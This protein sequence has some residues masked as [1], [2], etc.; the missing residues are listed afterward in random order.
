MCLYLY[1]ALPCAF[2]LNWESAHWSPQCRVYWR[3]GSLQLLAPDEIHSPSWIILRSLKN[4]FPAKTSVSFL[5]QRFHD[6]FSYPWL[7]HLGLR[8][9]TAPILKYPPSVG[10]C[11]TPILTCISTSYLKHHQELKLTLLLTPFIIHGPN[12]ARRLFLWVVLLEYNSVHFF[13]DCLWLLWHEKGRAEWLWEKPSSLQSL[14]YLLE[15]SLR[16]IFW[17][18]A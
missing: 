6:N 15:G 4:S 10:R 9:F 12:P 18:L 11:Q 13:T 7:T 1:E 8:N 5:Y 16:K 14:K 2:S 17:P 3:R